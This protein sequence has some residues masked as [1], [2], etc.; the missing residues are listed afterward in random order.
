MMKQEFRFFDQFDTH[1]HIRD[2]LAIMQLGVLA[3]IWLWCFI[4]NWAFATAVFMLMAS[5]LI[6]ND[7]MSYTKW[8]SCFWGALLASSLIYWVLL[9]FVWEYSIVYGWL[10]VVA[11]YIFYSRVYVV[12]LSG[13]AIGELGRPF[14][15][16]T[17]HDKHRALENSCSEATFQ[18][19]DL[20]GR[21]R[22]RDFVLFGQ[23]KLQDDIT[24]F[25]GG[26][27]LVALMAGL[28]GC[29]F[30][31]S[32]GYAWFF[33]LL[34]LTFLYNDRMKYSGLLYWFRRIIAYMAY[35]FLAT[36]MIVHPLSIYVGCMTFLA[37]FVFYTNVFLLRFFGREV[38]INTLTTPQTEEPRTWFS[39]L[40]FFAV[41]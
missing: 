24:K 13:G 1:D 37:T 35:T 5:C 34:A 8:Y 4:P 11:S 31:D 39:F 7:R 32:K 23:F 21:K 40:W 33:G 17:D 29:L 20:I 12:R 3:F 16:F 41:P 38:G 28:E 18:K 14:Y 2:P 27:P 22:L 25:G 6:W 26:L 30:S 15:V 19:G 9:V 36:L 10:I